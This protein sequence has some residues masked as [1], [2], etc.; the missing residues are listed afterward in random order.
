MKGKKMDKCKIRYSVGSQIENAC[1]KCK[2]R[3]KNGDCHSFCPAYKRYR[4]KV[5]RSNAIYKKQMLQYNMA[6]NEW[7]EKPKATTIEHLRKKRY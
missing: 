4:K 6:F 7:D 3:T 2:L 5:E 1:Y